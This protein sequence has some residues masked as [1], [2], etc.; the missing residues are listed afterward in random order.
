M[1]DSVS[2]IQQL[3]QSFNHAKSNQFTGRFICVS[4]AQTANPWYFDIKQGQIAWIKQAHHRNRRWLRILR[5]QCPNFFKQH[6]VREFT[7]LQTSGQFIGEYWELTLLKKASQ[8]G[9]LSPEKIQLILQAYLLEALTDLSLSD[10]LTQHWLDNFDVPDGLAHPSLQAV[11]QTVQ[12]SKQQWDIFEKKY[13]VSQVCP[14]FSLDL[15]PVIT[16]IE[17]LKS[18]VDPL[19]F[20]Q[21]SKLLTG[22]HTL[23]DISRLLQQDWIAVT[24]VLIPLIRAKSIELNP[25]GDIDLKAVTQAVP[26]QISK[27]Q[28]KG[29][30]LIAC[31]DDSPVIAKDLERMLSPY[32]FEVLSITDPIKGFTTLMTAKPRLIFLDLV[33][34]NTNGYEICSFLRKSAQFQDLPIVMLTGHDGIVDRLRAKMAGSTDFLG[35]PPNVTK[36]LQVLEKYL[37]EELLIVTQPQKNV[38]NQALTT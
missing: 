15:T 31:I 23:W 30:G 24:S 38:T 22:K 11:I 8:T 14:E 27:P 18:K 21:L 26:G 33:M 1:D 25:A 29:R 37:Q 3:V 12:K 13:G 36:V 2:T 28:S 4:Q 34:P 35:K 7:H 6:W 32:G 5:Q 10:Q 17:L 20:N 19:V 16:E 9:L